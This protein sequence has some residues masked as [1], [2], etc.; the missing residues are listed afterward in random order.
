ML[1]DEQ[2]E[3]T[4]EQHTALLT[5]FEDWR[6]TQMQAGRP[7]SIKAAAQRLGISGSVLSE[8]LAGKYRGDVDAVL[9]QIDTHLAEE[10]QRLGLRDVGAFARIRLSGEI[11]GAFALA[12]SLRS[13]AAII[14]EPGVCKSSHA[15]Y[16]AAKRPQ[17]YLLRVKSEPAD[18]LKVSELLCEALHDHRGHH[19][20]KV[21]RDHPHGRRMREIEGFL[22]RRQN[23]VL[24]VDEAQKLS[25]NGLELLRDLHDPSGL[26]QFAMP[27]IFF[28]DERFK[29]LLGETRDG[30]RTKMT[31]QFAS[32]IYPLLDVRE[33]MQAAG[34]DLYTLDDI[35]AITR[36][37]RTRVLTTAAARWLTILAN[38]A[39][40]GRLRTV[41]M[42]FRGALQL[43]AEHVRAKQPL[44][45]EHMQEAFRFVLTP[46]L[47]EE[48]DQ[49]AGGEL[50]AK[51]A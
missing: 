51:T 33:H 30:K 8:V 38:V 36:N 28:A 12:I 45:R 13:M 34:G 7:L 44:T 18:R 4:A 35:Q 3:I 41:M 48:I 11:E 29:Q 2:T 47:A 14:A 21:Y 32:R 10:R 20:L 15:A 22:E 16:L 5:E 9:R 1:T 26:R 31:A 37:P 49:A 19:E 40:Y 42:V 27:I 50:L 23:A 39:G 17:T 24:I 6:A 25:A 46:R 43:Y